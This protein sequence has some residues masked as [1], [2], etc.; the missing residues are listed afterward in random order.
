MGDKT[1]DYF[2]DELNK[3]FR[4]HYPQINPCPVF[5]N[6]FKMKTFVHH[7][8]KLPPSYASMIVYRFKC[9]NCQLDYIGSTKKSLFLRY[10]DHK[11]TSSRT[12]RRLTSPL[13]SNIRNHCEDTCKCNFSLDN[14]EIIYQGKSELDIRIAESLLIKKHSRFPPN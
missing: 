3:I 13:F 9:P 5:F 12:G 11:G 14:F 4:K 1:I 7:K 6:N 8:E 2:K 10:H